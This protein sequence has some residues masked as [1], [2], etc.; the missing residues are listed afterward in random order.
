MRIGIQINTLKTTSSQPL[1]INQ[2]KLIQQLKNQNHEIVFVLNMAQYEGKLDHFFHTTQYLQQ[3]IEQFL[4][5]NNVP[6]DNI[7]GIVDSQRNICLNYGIDLL[8]KDCLDESIFDIVNRF[9]KKNKKIS[10]RL[11]VPND[12]EKFDYF[13]YKYYNNLR[14]NKLTYGALRILH[15][16][17]QVLSKIIRKYKY[18][19]NGEENLNGISE[20]VIYA[21]S[22]SEYGPEDIQLIKEIISK[23]CYTLAN[24][25]IRNMKLFVPL[26]FFC[27]GTIYVQRDNKKSRNYAKKKVEEA[28]H[29][30]YDVAIYP[31]GTWNFEDSELVLPFRH[32]IIKIARETKAPIIPISISNL[33]GMYYINVGQR[34]SFENNESKDDSE[35]ISKSAVVL[36]DIL[37]SL[38]M[39]SIA[40]F[41][42]QERKADFFIREEITSADFEHEVIE[43]IIKGHKKFGMNIDIMEEKSLVYRNGK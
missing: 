40:S 31:E 37:A 23:P 7:V 18:K 28:L 39:D 11:T 24:L 42:E 30:G 25:K 13:L 10:L 17:F 20:P 33:G 36:R 29:K 5:D 35:E 43:H 19:I 12:S 15:P 16:F 27:S 1:S 26:F 32:G 8:I 22:H 34:I 9:S 14:F 38:K 4:I 41:T 2:I 3:I 6:Y 21:I